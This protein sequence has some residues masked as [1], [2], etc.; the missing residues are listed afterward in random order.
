MAQ[1]T[2]TLPADSTS[3]PAP[4][5]SCESLTGLITDESYQPLTGATVQVQGI[6]D[7]FSTNAEGRYIVVFRKPVLRP[8]RLKISAAG[9][10][11]QEFALNSCLPPNVALRLVPGTR[12]K[13]DGRIKK[14]T[15]TGKIKY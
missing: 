2:T 7:A 10:E 11:T 8:V 5:P 15:S 12:F 3:Q 6:N 4:P 13:R 14:T 1:Q 9:Y